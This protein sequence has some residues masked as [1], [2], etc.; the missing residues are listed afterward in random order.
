MSRVTTTK[1]NPQDPTQLYA[2]T[3]RILYHVADR[4]RNALRA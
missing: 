1:V 2:C 4:V 3:R